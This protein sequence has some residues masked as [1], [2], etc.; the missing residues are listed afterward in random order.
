MIPSDIEIAQSA[1]V[2]PIQEIAAKL[3]IANNDLIP[4]GHDKA[5]I[6]LSA[7]QRYAA[8]RTGKL[9]LM[10]AIS[11]T[12]AG[13]GKT[14]TTVGLTDALNRLGHS[15]IACLREPSMGP[16]FGMKGGAAGGGYAQVVPMEEINLHFTGDMAALTQAHNLLAALIDNHLQQG[17]ALDIEPRSITWPRVLDLNDR[18][19]RQVVLGMGGLSN[20]VPRQSGFDITVASELMALLCLASSIGDLKRRIGDIIIGRTRA[21]KPVRVRDLGCEGA[22][23]VVLR[24]ALQPNLVQTLEHSPAFV[25]GGPFANIAHGCSSVLATNTALGLADYVITEAGFGADLG[26]EKFFDI[27]CR[28]AG[29]EPCAT[30]VVA[31][32][33]ALKYHG[34]TGLSEL[35]FENLDTLRAGMSN[36]TRHLDNLIEQF[37]QRV[38]VAINRFPSD[39]DAEIS[40]IQQLLAGRGIRAI[41][42]THFAH[43]GAGAEEL[44]KALVELTADDAPPL[45]HPYE[46]AATL[47][48]KISA[49]AKKIYRA[50]QVTFTASAHTQLQRLQRDGFGELPV[51]IAK[52]QYSFSTDAN[53]RGA[54]E[55]HELQVREVRLSAGAGFIVV[56]CGEIMTMPGLPKDPAAMH[57]D[58]DDEG[59]ITGLS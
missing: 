17:N 43:G 31:T 44:A 24:D 53:L 50:G 39:T 26:A 21:K 7:A 3:G 46:L 55:G 41:E 52:T 47:S 32:V 54:P 28:K 12:P 27:K 4:Y 56:I 30:V 22:I 34:G 49:V 19:L 15:T 1:T 14:T 29:L 37:G 5:K 10:T 23:T 42:A 33:R 40:L 25:H 35:S 2:L 6:R 8:N 59:V 9:I 57:I 16:V 11:P 48:D 36:L 13:E 18:A 58:I 20:G 51:C 45:G 38:I